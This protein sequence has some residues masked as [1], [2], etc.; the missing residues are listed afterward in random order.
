MDRLACVDVPELP[1]QLLLDRNPRW[2][3]LPVAVV[4]RDRP[5]GE[6]LWSSPEA[7]CLGVLP[8]MR[9]AQGLELAPGLRAAEVTE[10]EL[11]EELSALRELLQGFS[12][13]VEVSSEPGVFWLGAKGLGLLFGSA[14]AW[15]RKIHHALALRGR[16]ATVVVGFSR[17]RTYAI[18]RAAQGIL[19]LED[20][21]E[22][23]RLLG[24]IPLDRLPISMELRETLEHLG[25]ESLGDFLKLPSHGIRRRFGQVASELHGLA[26]GKRQDPLVPTPTE[27][28]M[29][30]SVLLDD[31]EAAPSALLFLV[32]R[33][34]HP[35]LS[36]LARLGQA[37]A[38]LEINWNMEGG[39]GRR[40]RIRPARPNLEEALMLDLVRLKLDASP[41]PAPVTEIHLRVHGTTAEPEQLR[42]FLENPKRDLWAADRALARLRTELGQEAVV[43]PALREAHL[44]EARFLWEP[45]DHLRLPRPR[46][47]RGSVPLVRR[48]YTYPICLGMRPRH[49]PDGWLVKDL[50]C[51]PVVRIWGPYVV[52]GGWWRKEVHRSYYFLETMRGDILWV[53]YDSPRRKWFLHGQVE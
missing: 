9:Y 33:H 22:E 8:G 3:G 25:V 4:D 35:L 23:E 47:P 29:G 41:L 32:R 50:K 31:P 12:P 6:I 18:A 21:E 51:G 1:L 46:P 19:V 52:S 45:L 27:E 44:P 15:A 11:W 48:I 14:K 28:P 36:R 17:F 20:P 49:E 40:D 30:C 43:R 39:A 2:R 24:R 26:S 34:L 13:E 7:R 42:L 53:Y 10:G 37:V 16:R 5:Q 38:E